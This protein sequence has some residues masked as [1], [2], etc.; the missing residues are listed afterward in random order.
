MRWHLSRA[1]PVRDDHDRIVRWFGTNTDI[2]EQREAANELRQLAADL[3]EADRRK[4]EFLATL[5]HELRNPLA[6]IRNALA[7]LDVTRGDPSAFDGTR[8]V[9][10]RQVHHMAR[11]ID[12]LIDVSRI[13][14][15]MVELRKELVDLS[16]VVEQAIET[17]EPAFDAAA[18]KL[19]IHL[20]ENPIVLEADPVRLAQVF[21]N[22]LANACKYTPSPGQ[23][24]L[25]ATRDDGVVE[26]SVSDTGQGIDPQ[27]LP[28]V[29]EMFTQGDRSP[30]RSQGGLGIGLTLVKRLVEAH[31]GEVRAA[32]PGPGQGSTFTVRLPAASSEKPEAPPQ[33][34]PT[35]DNAKRRILVV[36]DNRDS[37]MS[38]AMLLRLSGN[39]THTAYDGEEAVAVAAE[40]QPD[41][42]LLDIG[43]P[44]L[45][46]HEAA[47]RILQ[48]PWSTRVVMVALTGWGQEDDRRKSKEAGFHHHLVKPV[49][50]AA[51]IELLNNSG[52]PST[53]S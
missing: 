11:L 20:P 24:T 45:N 33:R 16:D 9:M 2:T 30:S 23:I 50:H 26:I 48:Q 10:H 21:S 51:L 5:A 3:S 27:M 1:L 39:E 40:L 14:R 35:A 52:T 42:I 12:D 36:D 38:L 7:M 17:T 43:L 31:G 34:K 4:D 49:E 22:L 19:V 41:V 47:K 25:T 28:H 6:P 46:G 37:A 44:K 18:H 29:F 13:S 32:S 8:A 15:N 53:E